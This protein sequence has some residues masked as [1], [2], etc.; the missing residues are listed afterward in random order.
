MREE[1]GAIRD[2]EIESWK[3]IIRDRQGKAQA[4]ADFTSK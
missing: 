1:D 4:T 3:A 2:F